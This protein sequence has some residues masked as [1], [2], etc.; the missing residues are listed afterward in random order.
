[1]QRDSNNSYL[2]ESERDLLHTPWSVSSCRSIQQVPGNNLSWNKHMENVAAKGNRTL[3]FIKRNLRECT[4]PVKAA[5][6]TTLTRPALEY[7]STVWDPPTQSNIHP[8][9]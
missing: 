2:K 5:S 7:I 3:G 6:Y 9:E 1:M 4:K 8:L